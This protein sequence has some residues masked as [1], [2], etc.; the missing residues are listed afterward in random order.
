MVLLAIRSPLLQSMM[1]LSLM[2]QQTCVP[3]GPAQLHGK[4]QQKWPPTQPYIL[5][6]H[7]P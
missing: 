2:S 7:T 1:I 4:D 3:F 5:M 6:D